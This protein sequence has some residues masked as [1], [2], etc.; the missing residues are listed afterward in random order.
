MILGCMSWRCP[1]SHRSETNAGFENTCTDAVGEAHG[2]TPW[3]AVVP[4][5]GVAERSTCPWYRI[6][7]N[8]SV[9]RRRVKLIVTVYALVG[10]VAGYFVP[11][12]PSLTPSFWLMSFLS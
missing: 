2:C 10:G 11:L 5:M 8:G 3:R 1:W 6:W 9:A 4:L 7:N 12:S